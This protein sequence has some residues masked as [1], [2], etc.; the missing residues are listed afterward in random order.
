[1]DLAAPPAGVGVVQRVV[2]ADEGATEVEGTVTD[3][4]LDRLARQVLPRIKLLLRIERERRG[5]GRP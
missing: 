5:F 2:V 3:L 1:M 4:D